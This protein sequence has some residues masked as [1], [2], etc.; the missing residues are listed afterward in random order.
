MSESSSPSSARWVSN[1]AMYMNTCSGA[2]AWGCFTR[3]RRHD[4]S[5]CRTTCAAVD[6][7]R[8]NVM[9]AE[10]WLPFLGARLSVCWAI[11]RAAQLLKW[12]LREPSSISCL[13]YLHSTRRSL[14][15]LGCVGASM[16]PHH[17]HSTG[18]RFSFPFPWPC[19]GDAFGVGAF[20]CWSGS[21]RS[22]S[23][24]LATTRL[25]A[26]GTRGRGGRSGTTGLS[27]PVLIFLCLSR[28]FGS[29]PAIFPN[30]QTPNFMCSADC[31]MGFH[32]LA[33]T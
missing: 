15:C 20:A 23:G 26:G 24:G 4:A 1:F 19:E 28:S 18:S 25:G 21:V 17:G 8:C 33:V 5:S 9:K 30:L 3:S 11:G 2:S 13:Q 32:W 12:S 14:H 22:I 31:T 10:L 29:T 7:S 16:A 27:S 6:C